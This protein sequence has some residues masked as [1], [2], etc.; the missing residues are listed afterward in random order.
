[1]NKDIKRILVTGSSGMIGTALCEALIQEGFEVTGVDLKHNKWS[2]VVDNATVICDLRDNSF[3][4]KLSGDFDLVMHLASNAR[5]FYT[6]VTPKLAKDNF[7]IS[8][9]VLEFCRVK[10]VRRFIFGSSREVYGN[11]DKASYREDEFDL[12][13]C[14]SPYT[15]T[16]IGAEA[17]ASAYR[18]CYGIEFIVLR[19]SNVYGKYDDTDR[20]F[21][22]IIDRMNKG[23]DITIFGR[24]K[25]L[26]FTY[27]SD[28]INGILKSIERFDSVRGNIFNIATGEGI[29]IVDLVKKIIDKAGASSKLVIRESR[30]GEI[31][32]FVADISMANKLLRYKPEVSIDDGIVRTLDWYKNKYDE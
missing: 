31:M 14:E 27:I 17:L 2:R 13:K 19:F 30:T 1:V 7:D 11:S 28:C 3:F 21:P 10:N 24:E 6:V 4:E 18:Y 12:F 15:A 25:V 23:E 32:Q 29:C 9:N 16:K 5:V 26:D 20:L 8:F 22:L